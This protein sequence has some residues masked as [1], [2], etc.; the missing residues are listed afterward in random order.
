MAASPRRS[1]KVKTSVP[2]RDLK[3]RSAGVRW[4]FIKQ[5]ERR[6]YKSSLGKIMRC[7]EVQNLIA[8]EADDVL[9]AGE[10]VTLNEHLSTCPLCRQER[11]DMRS[12]TRDLRMMRRPALTPDALFSV[13][14]A[15]SDGLGARQG[16]W[17]S[18][19]KRPWLQAWLMP[20]GLGTF[21]SVVIGIGF[22]W[23]L[24]LTPI[25]SRSQP[26]NDFPEI[27][28]PSQLA[29]A[30]PRRG[31]S[32]ESP[33]VNP[34]GALVALTN[35]LVRGEMDD[36]EVVVVAEVFGNGLA[37]IDEVVEP[38]RNRRAVG[39]LDKALRSD[40]DFAPFV[41]ADLDQRPDSV[42]VVLKIQNVNV[43][44]RVKAKHL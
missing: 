10:S 35:S 12:L 37:K 9:L 2:D 14:N 43:S 42:R 25:P 28:D 1:L 26:F 3:G 20:S 24:S 27:P 6:I 31:V 4:P 38:S 36:D 19:D 22:I 40:P 30:G 39:E 41:P 29:Y 13:R 33:S 32:S 18:E 23:L 8:V 5:V 44:T 11:D 34:Q 16:F 17:I 15:V 21:A 7:E